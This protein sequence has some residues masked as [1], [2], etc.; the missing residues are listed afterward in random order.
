MTTHLNFVI[1]KSGI[2]TSY[3][4]SKRILDHVFDPAI[5]VGDQDVLDDLRTKFAVPGSR[6]V[7]AAGA[8]APYDCGLVVFDFERQVVMDMQVYSP[9][10]MFPAAI[11]AAPGRAHVPELMG[12][13]WL[14]EGLYDMMTGELLV[15]FPA[16]PLVDTK[17]Q[18][19]WVTEWIASEW[20]SISKSGL[21]VYKI[22]PSGWSFE[23]FPESK[24][25]D[26]ADKLESLGFS[27]P[28]SEKLVWAEWSKNTAR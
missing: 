22:H 18:E 10:T 3:L 13:G 7:E 23:T 5:Y 26:F 21:P 12:K 27:L 8:V 11:M 24:G 16:A 28:E 19:G 17:A 4:A 14:G 6:L 15:R 25:L 2:V 1:R 20:D 9:T